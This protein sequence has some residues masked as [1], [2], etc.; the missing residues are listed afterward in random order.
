MT[1]RWGAPRGGDGLADRG[2]IGTAGNPPGRL[3][4]AP[5]P[6]E[7][8]VRPPAASGDIP[9]G[10]DDDEWRRLEES[11]RWLRKAGAEG[12]LPASAQAAGRTAASGIP[13]VLSQNPAT[14]FAPETP[15]RRTG[16]IVAAV[17]AAALVFFAVG[18]MLG[19]AAP[20]RPAPLPAAALSGM[21]PAA[22]DRAAQP[23]AGQPAAIAGDPRPAAAPPDGRGG[24]DEPAAPGDG[25]TPVAGAA[26]ASGPAP[27]SGASE[28][29][30]PL[31]AGGTAMLLGRGRTLF[32][33]GDVAGARLLFRRAADAGDA[34]AAA[35]LGATYDPVVLAQ[36]F[37][38]GIDPDPQEAERWYALARA[39]GAPEAAG[40]QQYSAHR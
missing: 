17:S 15:P 1:N 10:G 35:A 36:R 11:I 24:A 4:A 7:T 39:L 6:G 12:H 3:A 19:P 8:A 23:P 18:R 29:P 16:R 28:P 40:E 27:A 14:F 13:P 37:T 34:A 26:P 31:P 32:E 21:T 38:R 20:Q 30:A 25:S 22:E 5:R 33:T 9:S 2:G